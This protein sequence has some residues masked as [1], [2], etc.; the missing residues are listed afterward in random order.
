MLHYVFKYTLYLLFYYF[1]LWYYSV[2][3]KN[4]TWYCI[5]LYL[6]ICCLLFY[7][8]IYV[9]LCVHDVYINIYLMSIQIVAIAL[10]YIACK[11]ATRCIQNICTWH[12]Y[13]FSHVACCFFAVV[14][15]RV[16]KVASPDDAYRP[17]KDKLGGI[18]HLCVC[19]S[20]TTSRAPDTP[21]KH[22][23]HLPRSKAICLHTC[24]LP[25]QC[26][27]GPLW[28]TFSCLQPF[29]PY[30]VALRKLTSATRSTS[31]CC[32]I[33]IQ[34]YLYLYIYILYNVLASWFLTHLT[35]EL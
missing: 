9:L 14:V 35:I 20:Q 11:L 5:L 13:I 4:G 15:R 17:R 1:M 22:E 16:T 12:A 6:K 31:V 25:I 21:L 23:K 28:K 10:Y 29:G 2:L 3:Q 32:S 8:Y 33:C 18:P 7:I 26:I 34:K 24:T 30:A 27:G 19:Q